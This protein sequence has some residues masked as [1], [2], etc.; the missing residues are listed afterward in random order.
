VVGQNV[1]LESRYGLG[2]RKKLDEAAAELV[3]S[4]V[5]VIL[6]WSQGLTAALLATKTI[7]VV[8]LLVIDPVGLG[9]VESL[10]RPGGNATGIS[11]GGP[12]L[13]VKRLQMLKELVPDARK[14][15]VLAHGDMHRQRAP[16]FQTFWSLVMSDLERLG[17]DLGVTLQYVLVNSPEE[18]RGAVE[19]VRR[20]APDALMNVEH[21][22]LFSE[23]AQLTALAVTL[24]RPAIWDARA[25]TE[26][27][28]LASYGPDFLDMWRTAGRYLDRVLRGTWPGDLPVEQPTKFELLFNLKTA[29]ALG[30]TIPPALL[31][32]ADQLIE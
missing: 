9:V 6:T 19:A 21:Q 13:V 31:A 27:G 32:R 30:F 17:R 2:D 15:T 18:L 26:A 16:A 28:G 3:A 20:Q 12:E 23:R 11:N 10:R 29:R 4:K 22:M 14:V 8:F 5:D 1:V 7:P 25:T 24:K